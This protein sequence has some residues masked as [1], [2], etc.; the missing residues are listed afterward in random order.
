ME[1]RLKTI[2]AYMAEASDMANH[3]RLYT[4]QEL[5]NELGT[6]KL[7]DF[8]QIEASLISQQEK[9]IYGG[10]EMDDMFMKSNMNNGLLLSVSMTADSTKYHRQL[11]HV[12]KVKVD[13]SSRVEWFLDP[14][15]AN[16]YSSDREFGSALSDMVVQG[17]INSSLRHL[18]GQE[19]T[20]LYINSAIGK[21]NLKQD[22]RHMFAKMYL[23]LCD[24]NLAV[25]SRLES[26]EVAESINFST[27][28]NVT[29]ITRM[30][31]MANYSVVV[32]A[33][34]FTPSE[35]GL[36]KVAGGQY[37][38]VRYAGDNVYTNCN[39]EADSVAIIS[40]RGVDM[41]TSLAWQSPSRLYDLICS[42]AC[43]MGC[44]DDMAEAFTSMRGMCFVMKRVFMNSNNNTVVSDMP[45][46][47]SY[48]CATGQRP[49]EA[50]TLSTRGGL[51]ATSKALVSELMLGQMA[52]VVTSNF[53]EEIGAY[54][55]LF[56]SATPMTNRR[57]QGFM[58]DYGLNHADHKVNSII[59]QWEMVFGKT[60]KWGFG[61]AIKEYASNV[62]AEMYNNRDLAIPQLQYWLLLNEYK[63]T[64]WGMI[65]KWNGTGNSFASKDERV[66]AIEASAAFTWVMGLRD[67]RP[68]VFG[69]KKNEKDVFISGVERGFLCGQNGL[70]YNVNSMGI[71]IEESVG[72]RMDEV[73]ITATAMIKSNYIKAGS[74]ITY[75]VGSGWGFPAPVNRNKDADE[76]RLM[77]TFGGELEEEY[78]VA[79]SAMGDYIDDAEPPEEEP[80]VMS[81]AVT[82]RTGSSEEKPVMHDRLKV[83]DALPVVS[84]DQRYVR[85][86][87]E[88]R[89]LVQPYSIEGRQYTS[90]GL[91]SDTDPEI[92][93]EYALKVLGNDVDG[94]GAMPAI[95]K[96]LTVRGMCNH[97]EY[98]K[99]CRD[100]RDMSE[101]KTITDNLE[102]AK[103]A[104]AMKLDVN[105]F[106]KSQNGAKVYKSVQG[107]AHTVNL[108]KKD[109]DFNALLVTE[110]QGMKIVDVE[111]APK[112]KKGGFFG[113]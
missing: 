81:P 93:E 29:P 6:P 34:N 59:N 37:P 56:G 69:N 14:M 25:T 112:K 107:H 13:F 84:L 5:S 43:K 102:I 26:F 49:K 38:S 32:D 72:T 101:D 23:M 75:D 85:T 1:P 92:D 9:I 73:E 113:F 87:D 103:I 54:G 91:I 7:I 33:N 61:L 78:P 52:E 20:G 57:I 21:L 45:L 36:L 18:S 79:P 12:E 68:R 65:R 41:E 105:I 17:N 31:I 109:K 110:G 19:A 63:N 8:A 16:A 10:L 104:D 62:A 11:Y 97:A 42:I 88:G 106:E 98:Q 58:R 74:M 80:R 24:Y 83:F 47:K 53:V 27:H 108:L 2:Q 90:P 44:L 66:K 86:D 99:M 4:R 96:D 100:I 28:E 77:R 22:M 48:K 89:R 51:F 39:M 76:K 35:L 60:I 67:R 15:E 30:H 64:C 46:S 71:C 40:E 3:Q 95:L 111:E 94:K 70:D 50:V 82:G 55:E